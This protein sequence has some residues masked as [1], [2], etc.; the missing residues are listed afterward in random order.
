MERIVASCP[1]IGFDAFLLVGKCPNTE[2][3]CTF[4]HSSPERVWPCEIPYRIRPAAQPAAESLLAAIER[5]ASWSRTDRRHGCGLCAIPA[6]IK[7]GLSAVKIV[8]RG[9]AT[10]QKV[11]NVALAAEFIELAT[12]LD[13][14]TLYRQRAMHAHRRRFGAACHP[15]VC[16]YP[17]FYLGE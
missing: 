17:E 14:F 13:D 4:H 5:Q 9:A 16:Y 8:G 7:A 6:L 1:Q 11:R 3:L 15:N 2:G 12:T 10:V